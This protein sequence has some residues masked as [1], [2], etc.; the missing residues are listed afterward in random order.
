MDIADKHNVIIPTA[1]AGVIL[2]PASATNGLIIGGGS[3]T[4]IPSEH[5]NLA[6]MALMM[7]R[8]QIPNRQTRRATGWTG[9]K[10]E[11][12]GGIKIVF[13]DS[14][15]QGSREVT[16]AL[17]LMEEDTRNA[18]NRIAALFR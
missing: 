1:A 17:K 13:G 7:Q 14:K 8:V 12:A 16:P 6:N 15:I 5:K 9:E 11:I 4:V 18:V 10:Q 3:I 2:D